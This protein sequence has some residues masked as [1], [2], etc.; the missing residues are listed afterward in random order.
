[1]VALTPQTVAGNDNTYKGQTQPFPLPPLGS[2]Y[3]GSESDDYLF[4]R[5]KRC[6]C[7]PVEYTTAHL[8]CYQI[9]LRVCHL[10]K[11]QK[12]HALQKLWIS[13]AWRLPWKDAISMPASTIDIPT[14]Q[15]SLQIIG[16]L[17]G[18]TFLHRLPREL[19]LTIWGE[20]KT[21]LFWRC[22]SIIRLV[23]E[24]ETNSS[25][26]Q[27]K[28]LDQVASWHRNGKLE[29]APASTAYPFTQ[30]TIDQE[31]IKEIERLRCK[32][33]YTGDTC[34]HSTFIVEEG[35]S[36]HG[37]E[38]H[39]QDGRLRLRKTQIQPNYPYIWN[40][41]APPRLS[42]CRGSM[43]HSLPSWRLQAVNTQKIA[44]ITFFFIQDRLYD[45]YIHD[46]DKSSANDLYEQLP[47]D[48]RR[49]AIWI[50]LPIG[51]A[52]RML[53]LGT[54]FISM[55]EYNVLVRME[56]AGDVVIG[57][58]CFFS[59]A[60]FHPELLWPGDWPSSRPDQCLSGDGPVTLLYGKRVR[61]FFEI[62]LLGAYCESGTWTL[63]EPFML[64][65]PTPER[66][67]RIGYYSRTPLDQIAESSVYYVPGS[68]RCRGILL[69][70][71]NGGCRAV[72]QCRVN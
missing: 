2:S 22:M 49:D 69:R 67:D 9:F 66:F 55:S 70:Y 3:R 8:E 35:L 5:A 64:E 72:G 56:K 43:S 42:L 23:T 27:I 32:P 18:I 28:P 30:L 7:T 34:N 4:C 45:I 11:I 1:H 62:P 47:P 31:G 71:K 52:D 39:I 6:A 60:D 21:S 36:F 53:V 16:Q 61:G 50:Y 25:E 10:G 46:S 59:E 57:R 33:Q 37:I 15:K 41:P 40:T 19:L 51:T 38:A 12:E 24:F 20:S 26:L 14:N 13:T 29:C 54:R 17:F 58:N 65:K 68:G 44:G 63:P 48:I